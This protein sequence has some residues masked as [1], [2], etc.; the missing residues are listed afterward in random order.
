M[1]AAL[2]QGDPDLRGFLGL[3]NKVRKGFSK[4]RVRMQIK[5]EA[6]AE[7]LKSLARFSPVYDI[8]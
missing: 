6:D 2:W 8:V 5:S 7:T 3:D 4:V 1:H